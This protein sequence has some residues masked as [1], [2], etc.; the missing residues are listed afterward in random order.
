[1]PRIGCGLADGDWSIIEKIIKRTF[2]NKANVNVY[3][4]DLPKRKQ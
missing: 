3:V 1:M 2:I 4:Y